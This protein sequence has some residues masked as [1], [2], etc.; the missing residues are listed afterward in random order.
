VRHIVGVPIVSRASQGSVWFSVAILFRVRTL[1]LWGIGLALSIACNASMLSTPLT[2]A[3]SGGGDAEGMF[4]HPQSDAQGLN[5]DST[6]PLGY[7]SDASNTADAALEADGALPAPPEQACDV[8]ASGDSGICPPPPS[9]CADAHTL[10]YY[11]SGQ[12][13]S[14]R[15]VWQARPVPCGLGCVGSCAPSCP[16]PDRY[17]SCRTLGTL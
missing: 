11:D 2:D 16:G 13:V 8:D 7:V 17:G 6:I 1:S 14:G 5:A 9:V 10:V 12:C 15:C 3:A 4:V